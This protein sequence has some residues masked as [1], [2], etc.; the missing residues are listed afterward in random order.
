MLSLLLSS[1]CNAQWERVPE[2]PAARTVYSLLAAHDTL[3]AGTDSLVYVSTDAGTDWFAG[4]Q[5]AASP[6]VIS[7]MLRDKNV[8]LAGTFRNGIFTSTNSGLSWQPFSTG[9]SGLGATDISNILIRRD[10]LIAGTLGAGVFTTTAD[11]SHPWSSWGDS[12]T[13]YEGDNVFTMLTVGNTVLAGAGANGYMFRYTDSQPWWNPIPLTSPRRVGE[14]VLGMA[15]GANAVVAATGSGIFRSTD[16]GLSWVRTS[17]SIPPLTFAISLAYHGSTFFTLMT[18]PLSSFL[19]MSSDEG[20]T[21]QSLGVV[22]IPNVFVVAIV[23]ETF[24][25]GGG[26]GLWRAPLSRLLTGVRETASAPPAFRLQQ[27]YPNP[28]NPSTHIPFS[29][30]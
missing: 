11:F 12:L 23:A 16:E 17:A 8:L 14:T 30:E 20:L 1:L 29:V 10:S 18:T 4:A 9:L 15:S 25:L 7:C 3:Y 24:Y 2:I 13:D 6:D 19:L 5:P 26:E 28:F 21:W 27:N 22:P